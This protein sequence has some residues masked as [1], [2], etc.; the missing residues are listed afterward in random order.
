LATL[1]IHYLNIARVWQNDQYFSRTFS[2]YL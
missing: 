1:A 2:I